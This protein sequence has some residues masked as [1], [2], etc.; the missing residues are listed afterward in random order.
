MLKALVFKELRETIGIAVIALL[1]YLAGIANLIG[2]IILPF[3]MVRI[4]PQPLQ[5]R[6]PFLDA[7]FMSWFMIVSV[8]FAVALGL[9]QTVGE[10][11]R[12]TWL[13]LLHRPME[14]RNLTAIKLIVG[15]SLYLIVSAT[16]IL[17]YSLWAATPGTHPSPFY[18][19]M[20]VHFWQVW[21]ILALGYLGSFFAGVR[22]GRWFGTRLMP[23]AAA[24][25]LAGLTGFVVVEAGWWFLGFMGFALLCAMFVGLILFMVRTRDYS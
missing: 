12:G 7:E 3:G 21:L 23:V 10:S 22:P 19:W 9:K 24:G 11:V 1:A 25:V 17:I 15:M 6:I 4:F 8:G 2:Y 16:A 14:R 18:W 20:T 13:L 5:G